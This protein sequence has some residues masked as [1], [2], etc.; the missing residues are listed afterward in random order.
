MLLLGDAG[1]LPGSP[2]RGPWRIFRR[3]EGVRWKA[4]MSTGIFI[5]T[6]TA[7]NMNTGMTMAE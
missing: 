3:R 1:R 7:M 6:S 5:R 2:V 4:T